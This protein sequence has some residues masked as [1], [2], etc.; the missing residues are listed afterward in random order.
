MVA[1]GSGKGER[2]CSGLHVAYMAIVAVLKTVHHRR[3]ALRRIRNVL[4][5][6]DLRTSSLAVC[7]TVKGDP[8]VLLLTYGW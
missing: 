2:S 1:V 4:R 5:P 7:M 6:R 3:C 8:G